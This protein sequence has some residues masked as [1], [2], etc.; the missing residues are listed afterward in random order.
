MLDQEEKRKLLLIA[1]RQNLLNNNASFEITGH[2]SS[3]LPFS[4]PPPT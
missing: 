4:W 1:M 2:C 3:Y